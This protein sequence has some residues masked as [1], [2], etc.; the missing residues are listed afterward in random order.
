AG[1]QWRTAAE[2]ACAE[3][4]ALDP[5]LFATRVA[6]ARLLLAA[7]ERARALRILEQGMDYWYFPDREVLEYYA[8]TAELARAQGDRERAAQIERRLQDTKL[9]LARFAPLR[10]IVADLTPPAAGSSR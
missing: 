10:P 4:L 5:R 7:G 3:A 8:L 2:S 1:P 6:Y 9:S